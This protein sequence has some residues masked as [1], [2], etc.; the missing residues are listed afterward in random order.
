MR[1]NGLPG[2]PESLFFIGEYLAA[3]SGLAI[4][5][6][7]FVNEPVD[8]PFHILAIGDDILANP[9]ENK[10]QNADGRHLRQ[11]RRYQVFH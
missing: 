7:K 6:V 2:N 9:P 5:I 3:P 8:Q 10:Q 11:K 4:A 1:K